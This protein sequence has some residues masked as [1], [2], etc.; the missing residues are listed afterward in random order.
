[1]YPSAILS[2]QILLANRLKI[3]RD[4]LFKIIR[5]SLSR[6]SLYLE[7]PFA[8][9]SNTSFAFVILEISEFRYID[10]SFSR[11]APG[12]AISSMICVNQPVMKK[13]QRSCVGPLSL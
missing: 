7:N 4:I 12:E 6:I 5:I 10:T 11:R 9:A 8:S 13:D 2:D 3:F 1:M